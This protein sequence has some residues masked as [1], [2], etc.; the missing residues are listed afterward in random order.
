MNTSSLLAATIAGTVIAS[1]ASAQLSLNFEAPAY[2][3]DANT[4]YS[5][6][7]SFTTEYTPTLVG[8]APDVA[9]GAGGEVLQ[10]TQP[11]PN[12]AGP[13]GEPPIGILS[14]NNLYTGWQVGDFSLT[15]AVTG[16]LQTLT[17][18]VASSGN[19]F[20]WSEFTLEGG[21]SSIAPTLVEELFAD[22]FE[23]PF[24]GGT[25][26]IYN[27]VYR[28]TWDVS[29]NADEILDFAVD[30]A[31][32]ESSISLD[33]VALDVAFAPAPGAG[34]LLA[35]GGLGLLRRRR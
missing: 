9:S 25:V 30:F 27:Q 31:T 16:D 17:L 23:Q 29:G 14:N 18:Q 5:Q 8:N 10:L 22:Q 2:R 1:S 4:A 6:W 3:G 26:T 33:A 13:F 28:L 19:R 24:P 32:D 34:V 20:N 35:V 7:E 15:G 12:P 21:G 11:Q